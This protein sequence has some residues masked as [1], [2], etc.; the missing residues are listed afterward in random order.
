VH[1]GEV[2]C[3]KLGLSHS[4]IS[5]LGDILTIMLRRKRADS[6][7]SK[8]ETQNVVHMEIHNRPRPLQQKLL[9]LK[10]GG[11]NRQSKLPYIGRADLI[12]I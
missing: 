1:F 11:E 10:Q 9:R 12:S 4:G 2:V 6:R 7:R 5:E 8:R 3:E